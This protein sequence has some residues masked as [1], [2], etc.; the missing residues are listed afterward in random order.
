MEL[1]DDAGYYW[2]AFALKEDNQVLMY[3]ALGDPSGAS[4]GF[5]I[6][7][8]EYSSEVINEH[9]Q[10]GGGNASR[11]KLESLYY[12]DAALNA[13]PADIP[14]ADRF[15]QL[16]GAAGPYNTNWLTNRA[17]EAWTDAF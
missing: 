10:S 1:Q 13:V 4:V 9:D 3:D 16:C 17:F 11:G 6:E 15:C 2:R 14:S 7:D 8:A 12:F 5:T